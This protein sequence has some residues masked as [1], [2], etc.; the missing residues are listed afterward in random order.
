MDLINHVAKC[1]DMGCDPL[2]IRKQ[3]RDFGFPEAN[4]DKI[5]TDTIDWMR[6]NP[7]AGKPATAHPTS[8]GGFN[9]HM[10]VGI[11]ACIIG[12][13]ITGVSYF[14]ASNIGGNGRYVVAWGAILFGIVEILRGFGSSKQS[15]E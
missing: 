1:L 9:G 3:L 13:G 8:S 2:A 11:I 7:Y 10:I 5:V 12:I 15:D 14:A 6:K 4:A